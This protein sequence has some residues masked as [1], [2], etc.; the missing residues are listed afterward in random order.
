[1][2]IFFHKTAKILPI[3]HEYAIFMKSFKPI[4]LKFRGEV[5]MNLKLRKVKFYF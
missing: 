2:K 3:K 4:D 1:M 5:H